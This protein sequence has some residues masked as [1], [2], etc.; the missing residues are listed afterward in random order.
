MGEV[1]VTK[2]HE[3]A[4]KLLE[5][6][7]KFKVSENGVKV[8]FASFISEKELKAYQVNNEVVRN[9]FGCLSTGN[10]DFEYPANIEL[11]KGLVF[12]PRQNETEF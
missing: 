11:K 3:I 8:D 7:E 1:G 10:I 9:K 5:Y 12:K 2:D 6:V 4:S